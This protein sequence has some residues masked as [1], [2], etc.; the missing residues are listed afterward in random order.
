MITAT[1][2]PILLSCLVIALA[3]TSAASQTPADF[4]PLFDGETLT[5]WA[6]GNGGN[7]SVGDGVL[8]VEGPEGWVRSERELG[9]FELR[10]E[11]RLMTDG[12][13]SGVFVRAAATETFGRGWPSPSYQVQLRDINQPSR[14]LP[15]GQVYRHGTP[16]GETEYA[17]DVVSSLYRGIGAWHELWIEVSGEHLTVTL[18]EEEIVQARG[19]TEPFGFIGFQAESGVVEYRSIRL[20]SVSRP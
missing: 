15:L 14:F 7:V 4:E 8:R 6:V 13:D 16:D 9:D 5:G 1:P 18:D 20:R 12:A 2:H 19:L 11:F 10:L 3:A 17:E